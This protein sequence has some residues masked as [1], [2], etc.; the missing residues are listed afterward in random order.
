MHPENSV[1]STQGGGDMETLITQAELKEHDTLGLQAEEIGKLMAALR[2]APEYVALEERLKGTNERRSALETR[3]IAMA[4]QA[5]DVLKVKVNPVGEK[6][7]RPDL[8]GVTEPGVFKVEVTY[9]STDSTSWKP[10]VEAIKDK[11]CTY[12]NGD[13]KDHPLNMVLPSII[14]GK[15]NTRESSKVKVSVNE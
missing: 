9:T 6:S 11:N 12:K 8:S 5:K 13:G 2:A 4:T 1:I 14:S 3:F 7:Q 10:V 15:T